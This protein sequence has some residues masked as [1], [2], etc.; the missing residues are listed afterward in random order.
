MV[1]MSDQP[2]R[3]A[4]IGYGLGGAAFHAPLIASTPGMRV[5]FVVTGN[6]ERAADVRAK[7]DGAEVVATADELWARADDIDLVAITSPNTEHAPQALAAIEAG[8][9]VVV[10]KPFALSVPQAE[11]VVAAAAAARVPLSV[12]QNRRW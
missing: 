11:N 5:A 10:D 12:F 1:R 3:V 7:Y 2:L 4:V 9:P 6:P 8:L